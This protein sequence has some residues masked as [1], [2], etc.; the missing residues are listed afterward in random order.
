[1]PLFTD[2]LVCDTGQ[3]LLEWDF[4]S[5]NNTMK[6]GMTKAPYGSAPLMTDS[7]ESCHSW[8][9]KMLLLGSTAYLAVHQ[10]CAST[11]ILQLVENR[12]NSLTS[13]EVK[14]SRQNKTKG[15]TLSDLWF[16]SLSKQHRRQRQKK[17]MT[18]SR[19]KK[20]TSKQECS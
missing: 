20:I 17:I 14:I 12:E 9:K 18:I 13:C 16:S 4:S 2:P 8:T 10:M 3:A 5:N 7:P 1:M 19:R 11:R 15:K 6:V